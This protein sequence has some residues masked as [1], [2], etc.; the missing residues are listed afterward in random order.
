[1][2]ESFGVTPFSVGGTNASGYSLVAVY[3]E[4]ATTAFGTSITVNSSTYDFG[5]LIC[6]N[7]LGYS[8]KSFCFPSSA[9]TYQIY[10]A[11][12][13]TVCL[14]EIV[15]NATKIILNPTST[16]GTYLLTASIALFKFN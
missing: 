16:T 14:G 2:A 10:A 4:S 11:S 5:M 7:G 15:V 6:G 9:G 1:M 13:S 8:A 12:E 3:Y